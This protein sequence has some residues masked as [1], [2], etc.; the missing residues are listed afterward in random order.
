MRREPEEALRNAL[1]G[2]EWV[3]LP[4]EVKALVE[5]PSA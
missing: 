4:A 5:E 2:S 1:S 3:A